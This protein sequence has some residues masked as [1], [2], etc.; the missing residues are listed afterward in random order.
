MKSSATFTAAC[1]MSRYSES[2]PYLDPASGVLINRLDI[3][4]E[5]TLEQTEAAFAATR[6]YELSHRR[7]KGGFD[8]AHLQ[9]IHRY[10]FGDVYGWA[11]QLRTIDIS[12]GGNRFA[13]HAHIESAAAPIFLQLAKENHL[14]GLEPAA[15]GDRAA[16]YLAS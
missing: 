1:R 16:Y 3:A 14:A 9:A 5:D 4:D 2:D 7:L 8:L 15:F 12:K 10:L 11:G 13:H 6:S